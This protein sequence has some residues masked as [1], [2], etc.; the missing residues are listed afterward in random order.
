MR[1]RLTGHRELLVR[2]VEKLE[3]MHVSGNVPEGT[4][5]TYPLLFPSCFI[6]YCRYLE[7]K[8]D[9]AVASGDRLN[10][11]DSTNK[12]EKSPHTSG[13]LEESCMWES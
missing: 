1:R 10:S 4:R 5:L 7:L 3:D 8:T 6:C 2:P 9:W 12:N 13:N 11:S